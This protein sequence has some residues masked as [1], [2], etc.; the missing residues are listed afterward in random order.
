M[1]HSQCFTL[2]FVC[3]LLCHLF[4]YPQVVNTGMGKSK[5]TVVCVEERQAGYDYYNC[6]INS[7]L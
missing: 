2:F 6:F 1:I 3:V 4:W 5:F 7:Q